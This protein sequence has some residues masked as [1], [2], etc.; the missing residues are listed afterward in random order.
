MNFVLPLSF[1]DTFFFTANLRVEEPALGQ[2]NTLHISKLLKRLEGA[3]S[4][5]NHAD[6]AKL[7][8]ELADFRVSCSVTRNN[9]N[10]TISTS[11]RSS[12]NQVDLSSSSHEVR[13]LAPIHSD[14]ESSGMQAS[15]NV[16]EC[17]YDAAEVMEGDELS[18]SDHES[19]LDMA[20]T[21]NLE[22]KITDPQAT[23]VL[24]CTDSS[25][26]IT[27]SSVLAQPK[28]MTKTDSS[29]EAFNSTEPQQVDKE[30]DLPS[31][32]QETPKISNSPSAARREI[33]VDP[34]RR[35]VKS[36]TITKLP[37]GLHIHMKENKQSNRPF[38]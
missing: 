26:I 23:S 2:T 37:E 25:M 22:E 17:Y 32:I 33:R 16:S 4:R 38:K 6:A 10:T 20:C 1:N 3:I 34:A 13:Q 30:N 36:D 31:N 27:D 29:H 11:A 35:E 7:A 19:L 9:K 5:G 18:I 12:T 24:S 14:T 8:H 21:N 28:Q 15:S